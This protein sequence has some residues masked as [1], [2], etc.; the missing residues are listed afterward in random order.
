[1]TP[2]DPANQRPQH[3]PHL[4][5]PL[6]ATALPAARFYAGSAA[7]IVGVAL[8]GMVFV[9]IFRPGSWWAPLA[10]MAPA[11]IGAFTGLAILQPGR[12]RTPPQWVTA[13]F[14]GQ[15][16]G[17][18]T[19]AL[20]AVLLHLTT[21]PDLVVFALIVAGAF[22]TAAIIQARLFAAH[23]GASAPVPPAPSDP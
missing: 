18:F 20:I 23:L 2:T 21:R 4:H 22:S 8:F 10:G 19:A 12:P 3:S 17:F 16:I 7:G 13:L 5:D 9:W 15:G 11:L 1:M 14:M 6:K